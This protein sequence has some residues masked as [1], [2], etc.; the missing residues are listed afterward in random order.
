VSHRGGGAYGA[1]PTRLNPAPLPELGLSMP[2][3]V[4]YRDGL[5]VLH[6]DGVLI[7][8]VTVAI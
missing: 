7:D 1:T 5:A 4:D 8:E 6:V 3:A 2:A